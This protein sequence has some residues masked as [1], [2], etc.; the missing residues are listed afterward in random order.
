MYESMLFF[1]FGNFRLAHSFRPLRLLGT[2]V[3]DQ[4]N[5]RIPFIVRNQPGMPSTADNQAAQQRDP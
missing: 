4:S 3:I 1:F 5:F 2:N